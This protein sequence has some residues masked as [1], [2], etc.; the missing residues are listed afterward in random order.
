M[1]AARTLHWLL[2]L[3]SLLLL[4]LLLGLP[5]A[6]MLAR[7]L[8]PNVLLSF[9]GP[10]LDN[11]A[12]LL[13]RAYY[14]QVIW[15][16]LRLAAETMLIAIPLGYAAAML[17]Q[18]LS[19]RAGNLAI[20]GLTFPILAGPLTVVLGWMALLADG[21]PFLGPLVEAGLIARPRL[22]GSEAGVVISLV[23]FVLPFAVLTLYTG[24]RQIQPPMHEAARS[25]GAGAL[26]RFWHVT[27]PLSLPSVLSAGIITFSL[28]ASSFISPHYLGG[29]G[30]LT[31]TTLVSQFIMATFN[32]ELAAAAAG[33]L[34]LLMLGSVVALTAAIGRF[35]RP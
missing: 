22:L 21:G 11:Y 28:A 34:L 15:R 7:S 8:E 4:A 19:G 27:L 23:Q 33:L 16:T 18:G 5:L 24:L 20:M 9:T 30:Q 17:L 2:L 6:A 26:S 32:A 35:I 1:N 10:A 3:P 14:L 12:Y 25:L 31:L 29:A 13:S